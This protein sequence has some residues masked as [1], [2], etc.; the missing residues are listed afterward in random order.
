VNDKGIGLTDRLL[1]IGNR[2]L[3]TIVPN[4]VLPLTIRLER[5]KKPMPKAG[6]GGGWYGFHD[7]RRGFATMNAETMDLFELQALMQH[8]SLT[9][10][11]GYVN[12]AKRL[13]KP[14]DD[15]FV[16]RVRRTA[17]NG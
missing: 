15:L 9:T 7:L 3:F 17:K 6:K 12:M 10:T 16:P 11:Q 8:K 14:V 13:Q 5:G 1:P 2:T 4:W